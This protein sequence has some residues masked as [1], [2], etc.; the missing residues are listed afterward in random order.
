M[1]DDEKARQI[2]DAVTEYQSA[3]IDAAHVQNKVER[4]FQTYREIGETMNRRH[5]TTT[6]PR[7]SDGKLIFGYTASKLSASDLFN[8]ADL[9]NLIQERDKARGRLA[10][11]R[12][13]LDDLGI[14]GIS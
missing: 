14:T 5:G 1:S 9:L 3:K 13:F 7:I 10:D 2:G 6:E 4:V 12:K 8:E 11:A